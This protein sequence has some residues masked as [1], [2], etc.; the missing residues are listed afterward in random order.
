MLSII[1][2]EFGHH[3]GLTDSS[4]RLLDR[5]GNAVELRFNKSAQTIDLKRFGLPHIKLSILNYMPL[6]KKGDT[7]VQA[8]II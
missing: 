3:L 8:R 4:E 6:Y 2:H 1:V 5:I 7:E